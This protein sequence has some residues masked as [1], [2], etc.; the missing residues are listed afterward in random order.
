MG[1]MPYVDTI[2]RA[3]KTLTDDEQARLLR[4]SGLRR[5][6]FRD[7]VL[8]AFALG[9][10]L[11]EHEIAALNVGDVSHD[12]RNVRRRFALRVFKRSND[13]PH[14]QEAVLPDSLRSKLARLLQV[15]K[16]DGESLVFDAPLFVSLRGG[17]ISTRQLRHLFGVWQERAGFERRF[18][19]HALRHT[20]LTNL[21]RATK[22]IRLVQRV[23]RHASVI[24]TTIYAQASD[25]DLL[26]AVAALP[27]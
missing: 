14:A 19:F 21:Y 17:R 18:T 15:K 8:F 26:R 23:A 27:C 13:D 12:G 9:T 11:R 5:D 16:A 6:G 1:T 20:A 24:S 22:D 4:V 7:H 2:R 25:E 3:P 10:G